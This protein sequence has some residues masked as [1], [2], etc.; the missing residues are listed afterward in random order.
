MSVPVRA[1]RVGSV[2][3]FRVTHTME[4]IARPSLTKVRGSHLRQILAGVD[5][6]QLSGG[7][8]RATFMAGAQKKLG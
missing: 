5:R 2:V 7:E 8:A 4:L 3:R 1:I 6:D